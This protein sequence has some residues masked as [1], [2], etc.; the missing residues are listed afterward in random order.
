MVLL[1]LATGLG[2]AQPNELWHDANELVEEANAM[3]ANL[4][5]EGLMMQAGQQLPC[6]S[7]GPLPVDEPLCPLWQQDDIGRGRLIG[8]PPMLALGGET[9]VFLTSACDSCTPETWDLGF[10][11]RAFDVTT[12]ALQWET[13]VTTEFGAWGFLHQVDLSPEGQEIYVTALLCGRPY[14]ECI[15]DPDEPGPF[16]YDRFIIDATTG[17]V[18]ERRALPIDLFDP[19][20]S[21]VRFTFISKYDYIYEYRL[22]NWPHFGPSFLERHNLSSSAVLWQQQLTTEEAR[23]CRGNALHQ[24]EHLVRFRS[25]QYSNGPG[26]NGVNVRS[27]EDGSSIGLTRGDGWPISAEAGERLILSDSGRYDHRDIINVISADG[28][29]LEREFAVPKINDAKVFHDRGLAVFAVANCSR[30]PCIEAAIE[31]RRLP[32]GS[33]VRSHELVD[34]DGVTLIPHAIEWDER[35]QVLYVSAVKPAN[36]VPEQHVLLA[37]HARVLGWSGVGSVDL[38]P[39]GVGTRSGLELSQS[40]VRELDATRMLHRADLH[41]ID[42]QQALVHTARL[43]PSAGEG[44]RVLVERL[45]PVQDLTGPLP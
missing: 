39:V 3:A 17:D 28:T 42:Q 38:G 41:W 8:D 21:L 12:G 31:V 19:D 25:S 36:E 35:R 27:V 23:C 45:Q 4:S 7:F 33:L 16:T 44:Q 14:L 29:Q 15:L 26:S 18:L 6:G 37:L 22:G 5:W 13:D 34:L 11:L 10:P 9:L 24:G 32:S 20:R 43:L 1:L 30:D 2:Q 40:R